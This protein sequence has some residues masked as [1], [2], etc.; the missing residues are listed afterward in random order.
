MNVHY[1]VVMGCFKQP[2]NCID[3]C[4]EMF[5]IMGNHDLWSFNNKSELK[6]RAN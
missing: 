6:Y 1:I 2:L 4:E 5:R 3:S